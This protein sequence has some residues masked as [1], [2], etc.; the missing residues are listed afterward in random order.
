MFGGQKIGPT[1]TDFV[2]AEKLI[3]AL[4]LNN[5]SSYFTICVALGLTDSLGKNFVLRTWG[6]DVSD[7]EKGNDNF[8]PKW[9][10]SFYDMDT[11]LGVNNSG[12][13]DINSD[14]YIDKYVNIPKYTYTVDGV[15][16]ETDD[17]SSV[18][19]GVTPTKR[20]NQVKVYLNYKGTNGEKPNFSCYNSALWNIMRHEAF[21][22]PLRAVQ[23]RTYQSSW[24]ILRKNTNGTDKLLYSPDN[25]VRLMEVQMKDCG[26]LLFNFDYNNKYLYKFEVVKNGNTVTLNKINGQQMN[27]LHGDRVE[28]VRQW[29]DERLNFFDGVF[30]VSYLNNNNIST[31]NFNSN[32]FKL[33]VITAEGYGNIPEFINPILNITTS[34]PIIFSIFKQNANS[35]DLSNSHTYYI[36][37]NT[38]T[39]IVLPEGLTG[40]NGVKITFNYS[41][42]ITNIKKLQNIAFSRL[43][44]GSLPKMA[45]IDVSDIKKLGE[46]PFDFTSNFIT[47]DK[48]SGELVS[49]LEN[50]NFSGSDFKGATD[51]IVNVSID[52]S[53]QNGKGEDYNYNNI[54]TIDIS[55]SCVT[56]LVLPKTPIKKLNVVNTNIPSLI[57]EN[58]SLLDG[59][60]LNQC[61]KLNDLQIS[62]CNGFVKLNISSLKSLRYISIN[63]CQ[64]LSELT[65]SKNIVLEKVLISNC[66]NLTVLNVSSNKDENIANVNGKLI[67]ISVD[68]CESLQSFNASKNDNENLA[69]KLSGKMPYLSDLNLSNLNVSSIQLP[70]A[71]HLTNVKTVNISNCGKLKEFTYSENFENESNIIDLTPFTALSGEGLSISG[72][73]SLEYLRVGTKENPFKVVN[74]S[75]NGMFSYLQSLKRIYGYLMLCG[76]ALFTYSINFK[77]NDSY[78]I[79]GDKDP[80]DGKDITS[81]TPNDIRGDKYNTHVSFSDDL[82]NIDYTFRKTKCSPH[83]ILYILS[84]CDNV[85]SMIGTFESCTNKGNNEALDYRYAFS[86]CHNVTNMNSFMSVDITDAYNNEPCDVHIFSTNYDY[87]GNPYHNGT[88]SFLK[89]VKDIDGLFSGHKV[90]YNHSKTYNKSWIFGPDELPNGESF[91]IESLNDFNIYENIGDDGYFFK[92]SDL[93]SN[94]KHLKYIMSSFNE[95]PFVFS[96]NDRVE[97]EDYLGS[98]LLYNNTELLK[99]EK[100][101]R[102]KTNQWDYF[103]TEQEIT[104]LFGGDNPETVNDLNHYPRKLERV[105]NSF[106]FPSHLNDI[107]VKFEITENTLCTLVNLVDVIGDITEPSFSGSGLKKYVT[108]KFPYG[109]LSKNQKLKTF[110]HFF[111]GLEIVDNYNESVNIPGTFFVDEN[112]DNRCPQLTNVDGTFCNLKFKYHLTPN[113]FNKSNIESV[114]YIFAETNYTEPTNFGI[115]GTIPFDLFRNTY[116]NGTPKKI[117]SNMSYAFMGIDNDIEPC[118]C[119]YDQNDFKSVE[120]AVEKGYLILKDGRYVWN[121]FKSDGNGDNYHDAIKNSGAIKE[122][123]VQQITDDDFDECLKEG[124]YDNRNN[125]KDSEHLLPT[126]DEGKRSFMFPSDILYYCNPNKDLNCDGLFYESRGFKGT[127]P[128][129]MFENTPLITNLNNVFNGCN[130]IMPFKNM[131]KSKLGVM[132]PVRLLSSLKQL[133]NIKNLFSYT[134]IHPGTTIDKDMF[135]NNKFLSNISGLWSSTVWLLPESYSDKHT[136]QLPKDLF[137]NNIHISNVSFLFSR[138]KLNMTM[139]TLF[140]L[141]NNNGHKEITNTEAYLQDASNLFDGGIVDKFWEFNTVFDD[142]IAG[143]YV[144]YGSDIDQSL[145]LSKLNITT[146]ERNIYNGYFERKPNV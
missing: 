86:H 49:N 29:L 5:A 85:T 97:G 26:E 143:T 62:N 57:I 54:D 63:N 3:Y 112:G 51:S 111:N 14:D 39:D 9:W 24:E 17:L 42:I 76:N 83:D 138:A 96:F 113:G 35:T 75:Y 134:Y 126:D 71:S 142:K 32:C 22:G 13:Q 44:E 107:K 52:L 94:L 80:E 41:N 105:A 92:A 79:I 66:P 67:E 28:Y 125:N 129:M 38:P 101:F 70:D 1:E 87:E 4:S 146:N 56:N 116:D 27:I 15:E 65:I 58:Q 133:R 48:V 81:I 110:Q 34:S 19:S 47:T 16:Y 8:I 64:N 69:I 117:I 30:M 12:T 127:I 139:T 45:E 20:V 90:F 120:S 46:K 2:L 78:E 6:K 115:T 43:V 59:I 60:N 36:P 130:G 114:A 119:D 31:S 93:I 128:P 50:I 123:N 68:K 7:N 103:D 25:F 122:P 21:E 109:L 99:I 18:P 102:F 144:I 53:G 72:N 55:N 37:K 104:N 73:G 137:I 131:D 140:N 121:I 23:V 40:T 136:K 132:Y 141:S 33:A 106:I 145:L 108:G 11:A 77:L 135:A 89:N 118:I 10:P 100:S 74:N 84:L 98:K 124:Y 95:M 82:T 61:D 91:M 88:F